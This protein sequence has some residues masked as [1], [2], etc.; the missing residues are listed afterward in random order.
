[1]ERKTTGRV[2][3]CLPDGMEIGMP[4][5]EGETVRE[6]VSRTIDNW[7]FANKQINPDWYKDPIIVG[8]CPTCGKDLILKERKDDFYVCCSGYPYCKY[9]RPATE[10]EIKLHKIK[11]YKIKVHENLIQRINGKDAYKAIKEYEDDFEDFYDKE[12]DVVAAGTAIIM[13]Y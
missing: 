10:K 11:E 6:V 9:V 7:Y 3:I 13:G 1:M 2:L 5:Y 12:L 4:V 8:K